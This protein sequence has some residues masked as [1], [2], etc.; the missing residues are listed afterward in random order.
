MQTYTDITYMGGYFKYEYTTVT[1]YIT[2]IAEIESAGKREEVKALWDTG[3]NRTL[4]NPRLIEKFNLQSTGNGFLDTISDKEVPSKLYNI[5]LTLPGKIELPNIEVIGG[6]TKGCDI[7]IGMDIISQGDFVVTNFNRKTTFIFHKPSIGKFI[8]EP[9]KSEKV[10]RN[11]PCPCGSGKKY[12]HCC[13]NK[14]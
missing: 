5:N 11:D 6:E 3:S 2:T 8:V 1:S 13:M 12:K 4:I 9:A 14:I 7:L 10:G